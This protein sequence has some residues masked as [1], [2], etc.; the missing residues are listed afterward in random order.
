MRLHSNLESRS[1]DATSYCISL[2]TLNG[3]VKHRLLDEMACMTEGIA[4]IEPNDNPRPAL[5]AARADRPRDGNYASLA[6]TGRE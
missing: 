6:V 2:S 4:T 3:Y 5:V 1:A